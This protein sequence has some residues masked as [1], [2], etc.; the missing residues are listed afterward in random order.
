MPYNHGMQ[1][2]LRLLEKDLRRLVEASFGHQ[3]DLP[4]PV[5]AVSEQMVQEVENAIKRTEDGREF[6]PDQFTLSMHPTDAE[7]LLKVMPRLQIDVTSR[8]REILGRLGYQ[9]VRD[10]HVTLA[11]DPTVGRWEVRVFAWHSSNPAQASSATGQA[12]EAGA[13]RPPRGAFV[14]VEGKRHFPLTKPVIT[15]GRRHDNDLILSDPHVSRRH[16]ELRLLAGSYIIV[17]LG[18]TSGTYVNGRQIR[19]HILEPGDVIS[20]AAIQII[21]GEDAGGPPERTS[22]YAP[23]HQPSSDRDLITPHYLKK[24]NAKTKPE[25]KG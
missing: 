1:D 4:F 9:T 21:Y 16:A 6:A 5:D 13:D 22:P 17:D 24:L 15:V 14:I 12:G 10:P 2:R 3:P 8:L 11:T 23:P 25:T 18:S 20:I 7:S 19:Q